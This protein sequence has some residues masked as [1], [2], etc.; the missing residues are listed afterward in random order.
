M[1]YAHQNW[2]VR[3]S[4]SRKNGT[5]KMNVPLNVP[6]HVPFLVMYVPFRVMYVLE[7]LSFSFV[8]GTLSPKYVCEPKFNSC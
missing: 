2:S 5:P 3:L 4:F 1:Y 8:I 6:L 7:G